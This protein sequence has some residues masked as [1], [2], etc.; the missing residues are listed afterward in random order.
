MCYMVNCFVEG[1]HNHP[2]FESVRPLPDAP[3]EPK[4][5]SQRKRF[6]AQSEPVK[7]AEGPYYFDEISYVFE[8]EKNGNSRIIC[9]I[10]GEGDGRFK[11]NGRLVSDALNSFK[12]S[13]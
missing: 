13:V 8:L 11:E 6:A 1:T 10:R 4:S 12:K 9:E 7:T 3:R 5:E 2:E